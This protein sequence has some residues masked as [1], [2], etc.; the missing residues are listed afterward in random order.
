MLMKSSNDSV[1]SD[2]FLLNLS[3]GNYGIAKTFCHLAFAI[4]LIFLITY[5]SNTAGWNNFLTSLSVFT[6]GVYIANVGIG[7]WRLSR[8]IKKEIGNFFTKLL[9]VLSVLFGLSALFNALKML[10]L[11]F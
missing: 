5:F 7:L 11:S 2:N 9:S 3:R 6:Y 1:K 10:F 8:K 4:I